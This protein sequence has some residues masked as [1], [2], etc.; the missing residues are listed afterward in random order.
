[1]TR[2][3][4]HQGIEQ[5]G[6][7]IGRLRGILG[8]EGGETDETGQIGQ[9]VVRGVFSQ[10]IKAGFYREGQIATSVGHG[11]VTPEKYTPSNASG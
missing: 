2:L 4:R 9:I 11:E 5:T 3:A 1:M 10:T 7:W 6:L 8:G